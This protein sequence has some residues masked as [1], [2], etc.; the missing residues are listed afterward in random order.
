MFIDFFNI[1][2]SFFLGF[3]EFFNL[4]N[5]FFL[6]ICLFIYYFIMKDMGFVF[7]YYDF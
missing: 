6:L 7:I 5:L 3:F 1:M 4:I 2:K